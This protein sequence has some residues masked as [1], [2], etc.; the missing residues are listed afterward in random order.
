MEIEGGDG[1]IH[2]FQYPVTLE[3]HIQ[4]AA[5][6]SANTGS[7][8]LYNL[9]SNTRKAIYHDY[10][11]NVK[12]TFKSVKLKAGYGNNLTE[13]FNGNI[14]EAKSFREEGSTN[15]ITEV[16]AYDW[17]FAMINASSEITM[18]PP[19]Y[20][21]QLDSNTVI[22]RLRNDIVAGSPGLALGARSDFNGKSA[23]PYS[24]GRL[25]SGNSWDLLRDE[26]ND[27][28]F[29]D[30]G[31]L[32]CLLDDDCIQ[33]DIV[34]LDAST[35]LLS[36]PKKSEYIL[37]IDVLFEPALKIGQLV[38]VKSAE[39]IFNGQFK[40]IGITHSGI[41][42]GAVNGKCRTM[43]TLH[44]GELVLNLLNGTTTS[45]PVSLGAIG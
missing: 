27:H 34:V 26:T 14:K 4:R 35:G 42:S 17:S 36:T 9:S 44:A 12:G 41:I 22:D 11:A 5:L 18:G 33:G 45:N 7:F 32:H 40:V 19:N 1:L 6:A 2:V 8:R 15:F 31:H 10:F 21:E 16:D 13:I 38:E 30:N 43:L 28:C 37:K 25:L 24:R 29:I 23:A 39:T 20:P 3:F